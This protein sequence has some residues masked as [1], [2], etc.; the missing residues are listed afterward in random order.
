MRGTGETT[1]Q[2]LRA[3]NYAVYVWCNARLGYPKSLAAYLG[4]DD[5]YIVSPTFLD[6]ERIR[7]RRFSGF[8][9][10]HALD[11]TQDQREAL[12]YAL[13]RIET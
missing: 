3:P 5:L 2:M 12:E 6:I 8:V 1:K 13:T 7:G 9:I 11:M 4:R 10:D